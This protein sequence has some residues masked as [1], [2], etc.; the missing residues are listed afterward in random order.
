M[1]GRAFAQEWTDF[2]KRLWIFFRHIL[3]DD[4]PQPISMLLCHSCD[5]IFT[6][7]RLSTSD[8]QT[9]YK[10]IDDL[11]LG[12]K[13][14]SPTRK[15]NLIGRSKRIFELIQSQLT[16]GAGQF[17]DLSILDYGGA[18]GFLLL[19]FLDKGARGYLVDFL[20]FPSPDDRIQYLGRDLEDV[21]PSMKFDV[22]FLLHTLE[23]V[24]EPVELIRALGKYLKP[25][26]VLYI[27]VPLG[28]WLEWE[29]LREPLTHVNFFSES[30]LANA[31]SI[32]GMYP[33]YVES[34]WQMVTSTH[35]LCINLIASNDKNTPCPKMT[36][37]AK[38]MNGLTYYRESL[39][40]NF[41][42]YTKLV[43][44]QKLSKIFPLP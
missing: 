3:K 16:T 25:G 44:R 12:E 42:Y 35:N 9:K 2:E 7:P 36:P 18:E 4:S 31:V 20:E 26:G 41:K 14:L 10:A 5:F 23:H 6:N 34:R 37:L 43:A 24:V 39:R 1:R 32:A 11:N 19:P 13:V 40:H 30:S 38:Q 28:A 29:F 22:V 17:S 27:E 21:P 33:K 8:I 15:A